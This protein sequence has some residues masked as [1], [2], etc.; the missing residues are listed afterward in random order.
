MNIEENQL[1]ISVIT[2]VYNGVSAIE[3]TIQSV[4]GQSYKN[5]EYI[6]IDGA[7]TDGTTD[8]IKK[9]SDK[10]NYWISEKDNGI[11]DAM[12]KGIAAAKGNWIVFINCGDF[13]YSNTTLL[14][15]F[16]NKARDINDADIIYGRSK[17]YY[18]DGKQSELIMQHSIHEHWKGPAFRQ[19][20]MFVKTSILKKELFLVEKA[21]K[22]SA[23]YE[24]MYRLYKKNFKFIGVDTIVLLY[25][26]EGISDDGF[27]NLYDNYAIIKKYNDVTLF[28]WLYYQKQ[29]LKQHLVNS[30]LYRYYKV[31]RK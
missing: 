20:A 25:E 11:Y 18:A 31:F 27:R 12:N 6:I 5:V 22:I 16:V 28:R 7:S 2:V 13:F 17:M 14:E 21:F 30:F 19:G 1:R 8:I 9:Y 29:L 23:D 4:I 15:I 10:I 26:K 24:L 3:K